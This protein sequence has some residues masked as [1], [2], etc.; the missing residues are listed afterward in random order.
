M[1][2]ADDDTKQTLLGHGLR[3]QEKSIVLHEAGKGIRKITIENAP[4]DMENCIIIDGLSK[5]GT[6]T[7]I[8]NERLCLGNTKTGWLLGPRH[9]Y[10]RDMKPIPLTLK[11]K[12]NDSE[13]K[14]TI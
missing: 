9:A 8:Q 10:I 2:C 1:L 11:L 3:I 12:Y 14:V 5:Y 7:K 4:F 6:V 13:V